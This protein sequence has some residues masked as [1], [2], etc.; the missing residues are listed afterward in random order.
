M[1]VVHHAQQNEATASVAEMWRKGRCD[2]CTAVLEGGLVLISHAIQP[3]RPSLQEPRSTCRS[4]PIRI[5][6]CRC[7]LSAHGI[8]VPCSSQS[9]PAPPPQ[10]VGQVNTNV[11]VS[12]AADGGVRV[13]VATPPVPGPQTDVSVNVPGV[14]ATVFLQTSRNARDVTRS[15]ASLAMHALLLDIARPPHLAAACHSQETLSSSTVS[16]GFCGTLSVAHHVCM[17][18]Q[19]QTFCVGNA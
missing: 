7:Y 4:T 19:C 17:H 1:A 3:S 18:T 11:Q 10:A 14:R 12:P 6:P 15:S 2:G 5:Q 9:P 16:Q 8:Y 13:V